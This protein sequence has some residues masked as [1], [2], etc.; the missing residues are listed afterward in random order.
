M[1][2]YAVNVSHKKQE[3]ISHAK[4]IKKSTTNESTHTFQKEIILNG[5][6]SGLKNLF[7]IA[8]EALVYQ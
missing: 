7:I 3:T 4:Y 5:Q 1:E 6:K 8:K 2:G